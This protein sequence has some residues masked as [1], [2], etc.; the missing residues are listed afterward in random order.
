MFKRNKK[1][2]QTTAEKKTRKVKISKKTKRNFKIIKEPN[3]R[4]SLPTIDEQFL[5]FL[6]PTLKN[7]YFEVFN[8]I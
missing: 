2:S 3:I 8:N 6:A 7:A 4:K 5:I 1:T